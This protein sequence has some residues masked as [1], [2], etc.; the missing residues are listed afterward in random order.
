MKYNAPRNK[1]CLH[2]NAFAISRNHLI[3]AELRVRYNC[4]H[5][6]DTGSFAGDC[7]EFSSF[8]R[9]GMEFSQN[10]LESASGLESDSLIINVNI[11]LNSFRVKD[12]MRK[13]FIFR[14]SYRN[15]QEAPR[16][17]GG[18]F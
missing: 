17:F 5:I 8:F 18:T 4:P 2:I 11:L 6:K 9:G 16:T 10:V 7:S 13:V 15:R 12:F 1:D 14:S 3:G